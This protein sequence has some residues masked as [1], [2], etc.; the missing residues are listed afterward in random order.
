LRKDGDKEVSQ[1]E[2]EAM[3]VARKL[4][5]ASS[6]E[7]EYSAALEHECEF[8]GKAFERESSMHQHQ[9]G[10][11]PTDGKPWCPAHLE[12]AE[13]ALE[14]ELILDV[15]QRWHGAPERGPRFY[16]IV[17]WLGFN[18]DPTEESTWETVELGV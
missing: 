8:C 13:E 9:T 12:Q 4:A 17:K 10:H 7:E 15:H 2:T 3:R 5:V 14:V 18:G 11:C 6:S 1:P 16:L